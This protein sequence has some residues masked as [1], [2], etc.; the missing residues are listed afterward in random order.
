MP[1]PRIS[2]HPSALSLSLY[3]YHGAGRKETFSIP[4]GGGL[5]EKHQVVPADDDAALAVGARSHRI[6]AEFPGAG[7]GDVQRR[8][9]RRDAAG[10]HQEMDRLL[11]LHAE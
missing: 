1:M 8:L 9:A 4:G 6:D 7:L 2:R 3:Y 10:G 11:G 5:A